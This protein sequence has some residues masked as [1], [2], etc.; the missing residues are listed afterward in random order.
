MFDQFL[1]AHYSGLVLWQYRPITDRAAIDEIVTRVLVERRRVEQP[2]ELGSANYFFKA[3]PELSLIAIASLP[4]HMSVPGVR[5]MVTG[6]CVS[7]VQDYEAPIRSCTVDYDP[8]TFADFKK[9]F[10]AD[11]AALVRTGR[12]AERADRSCVAMVAGEDAKSG[13]N[14]GEVTISAENGESGKTSE[15]EISKREISTEGD[16]ITAEK[17]AAPEPAAGSPVNAVPEA[18]PNEDPRERIKRL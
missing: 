8:T 7:F 17:R 10:D 6:L 18:V 4:R 2:L 14:A 15:K 12:L 13:E 3:V 11:V 1:F 9:S 5:E 16:K